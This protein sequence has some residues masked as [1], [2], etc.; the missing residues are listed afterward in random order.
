MVLVGF[1]I[2]FLLDVCLRV[3]FDC[4]VVRL[5][6]VLFAIAGLGLVILSLLL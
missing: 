2:C 6:W 1:L 4:L 3:C 5:R